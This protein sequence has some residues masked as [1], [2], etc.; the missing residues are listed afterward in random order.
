MFGYDSLVLFLPNVP[1]LC[2]KNTFFWENFQKVINDFDNLGPYFG[3]L[4]QYYV[5]ENLVF[6]LRYN[7]FQS[8][9]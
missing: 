1:N 9:Y 8:H 4:I 5:G 2:V 7:L 6:N 3:F